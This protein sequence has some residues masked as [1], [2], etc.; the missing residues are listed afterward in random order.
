MKGV[1]NGRLVA[2]VCVEGG[3]A[4]VNP[5]AETVEE[6]QGRRKNLHLGMLK[7]AREDLAL[8]LQAACDA[9][10]VPLPPLAPGPCLALLHPQTCHSCDCNF[11]LIYRGNATTV[12]VA[13]GFRR[14]PNPRHSRIT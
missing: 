1:P 9:S 2:C 5:K 10:A 3:Q 8:A 13:L 4:S 11:G 14:G 6:L 12:G 7:L